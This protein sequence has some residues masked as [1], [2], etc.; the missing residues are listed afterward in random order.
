VKPVLLTPDRE[1]RFSYMDSG[2]IEVRFRVEV[3]R[4]SFGFTGL[5]DYPYPTVIVDERYKID[6]IP[7]TRLYGYAV[8]DEGM[9][10]LCFVSGST[11]SQWKVESHY[12]RSEGEKRE[13]YVCPKELCTFR[14]LG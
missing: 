10:S 4:R 12:D 9:S 6:R 3:K 8:V 1:S 2:D 5:N 14:S 7:S 11:R 13:F